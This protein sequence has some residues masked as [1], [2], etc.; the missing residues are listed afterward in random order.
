MAEKKKSKER[1]D[2]IIDDIEDAGEDIRDELKDKDGAVVKSVSA[3]MSVLPKDSRKAIAEAHKSM[4]RLHKNFIEDLQD[5]AD[6][7]L[8]KVSE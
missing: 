7:L 6:N 2:D 1:F 4:I 5:A 3:S 8:K